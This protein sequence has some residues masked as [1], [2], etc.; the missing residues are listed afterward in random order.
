MHSGSSPGPGVHSQAQYASKGALVAPHKLLSCCVYPLHQAI[1]CS[2]AL[3]KSPT[4]LRSLPNERQRQC[5]VLQAGS[6]SKGP[7]T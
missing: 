5:G 7:L 2:H 1:A 3:K 4:S 6:R